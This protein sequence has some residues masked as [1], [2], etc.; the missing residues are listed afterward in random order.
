MVRSVN[1]AVS[2]HVPNLQTVHRILVAAAR[3]VPVIIP[4]MPVVQSKQTV[5]RQTAQNLSHLYRAKQTIMHPAQHALHVQRHIHILMREQRLIHIAMRLRRALVPHWHAV[6]HR[7]VHR[8][9]VEH[10]HRERVTGVTISLQPIHRVHQ[11]T[12]LSQLHL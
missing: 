2:W 3:L 8:Q 6:H 12:A 4:S 9:R 1:R 7:A 11:R 10:A 5:H